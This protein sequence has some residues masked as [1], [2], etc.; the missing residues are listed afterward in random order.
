MQL[1]PDINFIYFAKNV[2]LHSLFTMILLFYY[3]YF[4][5]ISHVVHAYTCGYYNNVWPACNR[6][7]ASGY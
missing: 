7:V 5:N 3:Y 4:A 2:F 1:C 6:E